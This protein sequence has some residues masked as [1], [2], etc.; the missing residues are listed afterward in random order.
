MKQQNRRARYGIF[1]A[2]LFVAA[3]SFLVY[4]VNAST[5]E[6]AS[7]S[8]ATLAMLGMI[9][10]SIIAGVGILMGAAMSRGLGPVAI[11][12]AGGLAGATAGWFL[13][14]FMF[15]GGRWNLEWMMAV[16]FAPVGMWL[17]L[18][19]GGGKAE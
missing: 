1:A 4:L 9:A 8:L 5:M 11:V 2:G 13:G 10:G 19:A 3:V 18:L 17:G 14:S 15:S 6:G 12:L 7:D 16:C